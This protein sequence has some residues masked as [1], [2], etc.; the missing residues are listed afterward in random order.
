M[1][2]RPL[3]DR[4]VVLAP[5]PE[6]V[7]SG[8]IVIP[9]TAAQ[10]EKVFLRGV[11]VAVG[12]GKIDERGGAVPIQAQVGEMVVFSKYAGTMVILNEGTA[13]EEQYFIVRD[14]DVLG[15]LEEEPA[16]TVESILG[17][18]SK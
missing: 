13:A 9:K 2:I 14:G 7:T 4:V 15:V 16:V 17:T 10:E 1:R 5:K 18:D 12:P 11:V 6:E 8:G 3:Y